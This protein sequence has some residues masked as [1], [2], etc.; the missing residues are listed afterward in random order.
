[1]HVVLFSGAWAFVGFAA[2]RHFSGQ[3][4]SRFESF[5]STPS[6]HST[7]SG[8][9]ET[10]KQTVTTHSGPTM[11][12]SNVRAAS[13]GHVLQHAVRH[14]TSFV[15]ENNVGPLEMRAAIIA[16]LEPDGEDLRQVL[17]ELLPCGEAD[18]TNSDEPVVAPENTRHSFIAALL[19][20]EWLCV[21][22]S[23]LL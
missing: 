23:R 15:T 1:M 20:A 12:I 19:F 21:T 22:S 7:S 9:V 6:T 13:L 3:Q 2:W 11:T 14:A 10:Q 5:H 17:K 18:H 8:R 16:V 4:V